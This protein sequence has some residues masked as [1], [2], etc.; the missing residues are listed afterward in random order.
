VIL[1]WSVLVVR[2]IRKGFWPVKNPAAVS[3]LKT[4]PWSNF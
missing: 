4:W 1:F 3:E 2:Y